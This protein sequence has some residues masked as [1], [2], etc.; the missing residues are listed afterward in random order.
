MRDKGEVE[1]EEESEDVERC[2]WQYLWQSCECW[3]MGEEDRRRKGMA[4]KMGEEVQVHF[5]V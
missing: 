3:K 1:E 5:S 2:R 4:R